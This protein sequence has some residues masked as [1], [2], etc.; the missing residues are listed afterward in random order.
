ME[1]TEKYIYLIKLVKSL[2]NKWGI[3]SWAENKESERLDRLYI[4][5]EPEQIERNI[6]DKD[7][8]IE[9]ANDIWCG[10]YKFAEFDVDRWEY[11]WIWEESDVDIERLRDNKPA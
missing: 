10:L 1:T 8:R 9:D 4:S 11:G 3:V 5:I 6:D 2:V 7:T